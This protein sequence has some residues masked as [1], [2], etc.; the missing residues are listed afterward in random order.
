VRHLVSAVL[1]CSLAACGGDSTGPST[2]E[3]GGAWR[4]AWTNLSG[5]GVSC[6]AV[7]DFQLTQSGTTF[8][9]VQTGAGTL[10]CLANG[11]AFEETVSG[12]TLTAGAVTGNAVSFRVG[13]VQST[14][15]GT[16]TGT[17]M[18]GTASWT[19]DLGGNV[20]VALNGQWSAVKL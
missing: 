16:V 9:G 6:N 8:S 5:S 15:N 11:E 3:V 10:I 17:S 13:S 1:I 19:F 2:A 12:E 20:T 4:F 7:A 14:H 18:N